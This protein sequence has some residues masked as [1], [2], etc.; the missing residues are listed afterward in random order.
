MSHNITNIKVNL[1]CLEE[2]GNSSNRQYIG[3]FFEEKR[4]TGKNKSVR[5]LCGIEEVTNRTSGRQ[6]ESIA[7][8]VDNLSCGIKEDFPPEREDEFPIVFLY[9]SLDLSHHEPRVEITYKACYRYRKL[10]QGELE[11]IATKLRENLKLYY[12]RSYEHLE[13]EKERENTKKRAELN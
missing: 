2:I 13:E 4:R 5:N 11:E 9:S 10:E 1:L 8:V 7:E 6:P 3:S 12:T